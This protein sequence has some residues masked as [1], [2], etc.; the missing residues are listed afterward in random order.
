MKRLW[1]AW[2]NSLRGLKLA[3][4]D[5][6]A[7]REEI[8]LAIV[9]SPAAWF[10]ADNS[11]ELAI[12]WGCLWLLLIVELINTAIEAAIDRIGPEIHPL[13]GKAKDA[14]SAAVLLALINGIILWAL[15][16]AN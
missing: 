12:M 4:R 9:L 3:L 2:L 14:A 13:A 8:L 6:A 16:L 15:M 7:F 11:I 1:H 10:L 5:E